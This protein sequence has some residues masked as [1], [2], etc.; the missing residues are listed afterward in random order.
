[1]YVKDAAR[2]KRAFQVSAPAASQ[3]FAM[4][5][6]WRNATTDLQRRFRRPALVEAAYR[7]LVAGSIACDNYFGQTEP[8][9]DQHFPEEDQK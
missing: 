7:A 5:A 4:Y 2:F 9:P 1:M 8:I 3:V 6:R